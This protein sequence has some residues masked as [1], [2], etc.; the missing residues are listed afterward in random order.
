MHQGHNEKAEVL[1][2]RF[3]R[4]LLN[5]LPILQ[6]LPFRVKSAVNICSVVARNSWAAFS[7]SATSLLAENIAV[8]E[9]LFDY[10]GLFLPDTA[11]LF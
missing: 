2:F 11:L 7:H 10:G 9:S 5:I 1:G 3:D 8:P 6:K 4:S